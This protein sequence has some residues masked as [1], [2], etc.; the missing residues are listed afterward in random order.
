MQDIEQNKDARYD[1]KWKCN[2]IHI[3]KLS[4]K[5]ETYIEQEKEKK[6][7]KKNPP[8]PWKYYLTFKTSILRNIKR[9]LSIKINLGMNRYYQ[10]IFSIEYSR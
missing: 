1:T 9:L 4:Q 10:L 5:V 2:K 8:K 6:Y 3:N 7:K